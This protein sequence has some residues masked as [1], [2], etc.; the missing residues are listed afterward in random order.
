MPNTEREDTR[1]LC[2]A[3]LGRL[4]KWLRLLGYDTEY[5]NRV[6]DIA[7]LKA[8]RENHRVLLTRDTLIMKRRVVK[9]GELPALLIESDNYLDQLSQVIKEYK[10]RKDRPARCNICNTAVGDLDKPTAKGRVPLYVYET[11]ESFK[12]CPVCGRVYWP[13]SHWE[14]IKKVKKGINFARENRKKTG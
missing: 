6:D 5:L 10:L 2:D 13:A 1:F 12:S 11:E 7:L 14:N 4:A 8:A 9:S 3:M